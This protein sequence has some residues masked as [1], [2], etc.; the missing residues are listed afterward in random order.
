MPTG[1]L[2]G[3]AAEPLVGL[4]GVPP[5]VAGRVKALFLKPV[6]PPCVEAVLSVVGFVSEDAVGLCAEAEKENNL[7]VVASERVSTK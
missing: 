1:L 6:K 3:G 5:F 2:E 7:V 4:E